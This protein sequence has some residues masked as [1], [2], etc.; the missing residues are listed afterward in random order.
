[1]GRGA[2]NAHLQAIKD[3]ILAEVPEVDVSEV[4]EQVEELL[5]L[6][7]TAGEFVI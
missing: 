2:I 5:D 3:Q 1:M 6:S 7:I 4:M